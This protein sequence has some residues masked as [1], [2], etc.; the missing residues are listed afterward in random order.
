MW[1]APRGLI[2]ALDG[3]L[4]VA[5]PKTV[6]TNGAIPGDE[7]P[8]IDGA[9]LELLDLRRAFGGVVAVD[10]VT[11]SIPAGSVHAIVGP[12]GS[13]KTTL[14]NLI[15]G[16]YR[17]DSGSVL[18]DGREITGL[19]P[20]SIALSAVGR[21]F[22]TPK[23]LPDLS[24]L[25]NVML[26]A[27]GRG[28]ASIPELG[29]C[30]PRARSE[31]LTQRRDAADIL[32]FVDLDT[33]AADPAGEVPHGQQRLAEI[34]RAL[35]GRPRLLLLDEPAAG[36]S[37]GELDRLGRLIKSIAHQ[38]TT[39]VIV[40][41]HL[42]LVGNTCDRTTVLERGSILASGTPQEVF[43]HPAVVAAYM[44]R[45]DQVMEVKHD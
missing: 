31:A 10:G 35:I 3:L 32:R 24:V 25:E 42:E 33:R 11:L 9:A 38:G 1:F 34:A 43:A 45:R 4:P 17:P 37:M 5:K 40:E 18:L 14:L 36:L 41:H 20:T 26:G 13:G 12:N 30:L 44:G 39:V 23:L 6:P 15:S 28:R 16:Y 2:G 7:R 27:Y 21:T 8:H 19:S 29:L 22:Q